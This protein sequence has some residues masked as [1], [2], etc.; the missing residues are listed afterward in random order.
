MADFELGQVFKGMI[1]DEPAT[2]VVV[3]ANGDSATLAVAP[4]RER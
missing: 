2:L 3:S 1:G 4:A